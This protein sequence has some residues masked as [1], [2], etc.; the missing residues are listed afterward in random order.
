MIFSENIFIGQDWTFNIIFLLPTNQRFWLNIKLKIA[1]I[2]HVYD[3]DNVY[4]GY[5][6]ASV[7]ILSLS[8]TLT[9]YSFFLLYLKCVIILHVTTSSNTIKKL[10]LFDVIWIYGRYCD[11]CVKEWD[12]GYYVR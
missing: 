4:Y 2:F 3:Y 7:N 8:Y 6:C 10:Y 5:S 1:H 9:H 12:F 11:V